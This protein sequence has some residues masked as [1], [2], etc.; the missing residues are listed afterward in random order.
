LDRPKDEIYEWLDAS[1]EIGHYKFN[2]SSWIKGYRPVTQVQAFSARLD[3]IFLM[4]NPTKAQII[5]AFHKTNP[6][7]EQIL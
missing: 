1:L 5:D 7:S 6:K 2:Y 4:G 3:S